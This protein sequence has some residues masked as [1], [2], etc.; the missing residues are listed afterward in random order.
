MKI[1]FVSKLTSRVPSGPNWSVPAR[2]KAQSK[3]DDVYWINCDDSMMPHW[4]ETGLLHTIDDIGGKLRLKAIILNFGK[5]D[6]VIFEGAFFIQYLSF[7]CQLRRRK[8]PY[9]I[10][11]RSSFTY[12][13][14]NNHAKWKKKVA[15]WLFFNRFFKGARAIQYLTPNEQND[16]K[17]SF[18]PIGF[19]V[20]NGIDVQDKYR[21][22]SKENIVGVYVGR[23]NIY[24][25]GLDLLLNAVT[26]NA[27]FLRKMNLRLHIYGPQNKDYE[28]LLDKVKHNSIEDLFCLKGEIGGKTKEMALRDADF[29]IMTSRF[30]GLP[31]ALLEALSYSVPCV[32]TDG[33]NM[34]KEVEEYEAGIGCDFTIKDIGSTLCKIAKVPHILD[35][36]REN[37]Y[38]LAGQYKWEKQAEKLHKILTGLI[39]EDYTPA[40]KFNL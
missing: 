39:R 37:A 17:L 14:M 20:A 24:Q 23:I 12:Q 27:D 28:I 29:F 10:V 3:I 21:H 32:V 36:Y 15:G 11:P 4:E 2:I 30:E 38:I 33:T 22:L 8:I 25:K 31:M 13:G 7:A 35:N 16:S 34:R 5:P 18:L 19:I 9:I 26:D 6:I 40:Y 1:L